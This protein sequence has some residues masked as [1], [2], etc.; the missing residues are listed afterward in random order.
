MKE[1]MK[2]AAGIAVVVPGLAFANVSATQ[3]D[4]KDKHGAGPQFQVDFEVLPDVHIGPRVGLG[5][6][7]GR[8]G[9]KGD[10][11]GIGIR[12]EFGGIDGHKGGIGPNLVAPNPFDGVDETN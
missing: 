11:I 5:D 8:I 12:I 3:P 9:H 10:S 1:L 2:L 7:S 6:P 4:P